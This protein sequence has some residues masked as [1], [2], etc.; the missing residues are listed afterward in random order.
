MKR[1][2]ILRLVISLLGLGLAMPAV[3]KPVQL[4]TAFEA[5]QP[6]LPPSKTESP[7]APFQ[8]SEIAPV[9]GAP[10]I[11]VDT[12]EAGAQ[13]ATPFPVKI[14]FVPS[15]GSKINVSSVKIE[16]LKLV[17]ISLLSRVKPYLSAAGINVP[18][19]KIPAGTYNVRVAVADDQ[20]REAETV[21]TWIVK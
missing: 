7:S 19:A 16:V 12:P 8:K 1:L 18:E 20:G 15:A 6:D 14:R 11:V 10:Q 13:V 3:A 5:A 9:A 21:Q 4:L 2:P 17:A